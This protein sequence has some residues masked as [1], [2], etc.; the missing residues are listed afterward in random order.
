M[1]LQFLFCMP[2]IYNRLVVKLQI[3]ERKKSNTDNKYHEMEKINTTT[4]LNE[5]AR[6]GLE[7]E[8]VLC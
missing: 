4:V 5:N 1:E 7:D 2:L 6:L 3:R 8:M